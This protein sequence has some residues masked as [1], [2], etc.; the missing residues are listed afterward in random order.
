M[1]L[2]VGFYEQS[3]PP[4]VWGGGGGA[5]AT[6]AQAGKP[7]HWTPP[8]STPPGNIEAAGT[9]PATPT[10]PWVAGQSVA[11][12][13]GGGPIW[14]NG[15][16]WLAG[17]CPPT[18]GTAG[19]PGAWSGGAAP[20]SFQDIQDRLAGSYSANNDRD[21]ITATPATAW[22]TGAHVLAGIDAVY[23]DGTAWIQGVAP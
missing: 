21:V 15:A 12:A 3:Y 10:W 7:G 5:P 9:I 17:I 16:A 23:W 13:G 20:S 11:L 1:T 6:G 18:V 2:P 4:S 8:G 19:T 14:W 22:A